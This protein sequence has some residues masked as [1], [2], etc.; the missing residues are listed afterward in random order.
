MMGDVV[1]KHILEFMCSGVSD[2]EESGYA[3][4]VAAL[5]RNRQV[6]VE[7]G[8]SLD[9]GDVTGSIEGPPWTDSSGN[10]G[11]QW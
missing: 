5:D 11:R 10:G 1:R 3:H 8:M 7:E 9:A 2:F 6:E 4:G